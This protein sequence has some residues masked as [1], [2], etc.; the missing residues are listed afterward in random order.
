MDD[1]PM[2][3]EVAEAANGSLDEVDTTNQNVHLPTKNVKNEVK[4]VILIFLVQLKFMG[5][6]FLPCKV[7]F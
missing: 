5:S 6:W 3:K 2:L 4:I 1:A 7:E